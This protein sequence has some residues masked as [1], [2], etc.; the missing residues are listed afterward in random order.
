VSS[1]VFGYLSDTVWFGRKKSIL[2]CM[3]LGAL[4]SIF[5]FLFQNNFFAFLAANFATGLVGGSLAVGVAYVS[6][7]SVNRLKTDAEIGTTIA[8]SLIGRTGG[9]I[10][11][12]VLQKFG[13]FVPLWGGVVL[14]IFAGIICQFLLV[15]PPKHQN[16]AVSMA[17]VDLTDNTL[18]DSE[19]D[20]GN[21]GEDDTDFRNPTALD[22]R[23]L[24]HIMLGELADNLGSLGLVPLCLSCL[25]FRTFYAEFVEK[26]LEPIMSA[27]SYKWIYVFVA[28]I[29]LPGAAIAPTLFQRFG[30]ALSCTV[31]NLLTS[32]VIVALL[33]I[34]SIDPPTF[35]TYCIFVSV[36]YIAFPF[37]VISQLSTAPMM[38]RI[39]PLHQRGYVQGLNMATMNFATAVGEFLFSLLYDYTNIHITLY[40]TVGVSVAAAVINSGLIKDARFGPETP[41]I[42]LLAISKEEEPADLDIRSQCDDDDDDGD[43]EPIEIDC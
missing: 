2:C 33:Q 39:T 4:G 7:L 12:I 11:A 14:T 35:T 16:P 3:Y 41:T 36:L 6:D 28:T 18:E 25:L 5:K 9:G 27:T 1:I 23:A 31:A 37:T 42:T 20:D 15:E 29:V 32:G 26:G 22:K 43:D 24:R 8:I 10:L 17:A 30:P 40:T 13:L 38:D 21:S 19:H 34:G